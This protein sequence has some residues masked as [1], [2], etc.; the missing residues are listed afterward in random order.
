[1][2]VTN[3]VVARFN[4]KNPVANVY[5]FEWMEARSVQREIAAV[6]GGSR[7]R[8]LRAKGSSGGFARAA[9]VDH[10]QPPPR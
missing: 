5:W 7:Y 10:T 8:A 4:R 6:T 2:I 9:C 1:M 3:G